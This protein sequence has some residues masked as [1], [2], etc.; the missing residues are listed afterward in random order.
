MATNIEHVLKTQTNM[1]FPS[2]AKRRSQNEEAVEHTLCRM[3]LSVH[4][5]YYAI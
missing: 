3:A 2:L 1:S 5:K 4:Q